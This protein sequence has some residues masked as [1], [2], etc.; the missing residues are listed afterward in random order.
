MRMVMMATGVSALFLLCG[1][2]G[3]L[4]WPEVMLIEVYDGDELVT[5]VEPSNSTDTTIMVDVPPSASFVVHFSEPM[6]LD[7]IEER[8]GIFDAYFEEY[9]LDIDQRLDTITISTDRCRLEPGLNHTLI[10]NDGIQDTTGLA[11]VM[12]YVINFYV[13]ERN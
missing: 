4:Q 12:S 13:E 11:T 5:S 7:S 2:P 3:D 1:C 6:A 9:D 8:V 10:I